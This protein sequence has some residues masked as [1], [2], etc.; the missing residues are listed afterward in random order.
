MQFSEVLKNISFNM[1]FYFVYQVRVIDEE[2]S[3]KVYE[4]I[5]KHLDKVENDYLPQ[6]KLDKT[7]VNLH[8][9]QLLRLSADDEIKRIFSNMGKKFLQKSNTNN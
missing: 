8:C 9:N 1:F 3:K 2:K 6:V 5:M 7:E 4:D